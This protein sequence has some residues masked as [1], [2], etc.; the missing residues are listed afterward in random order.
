MDDA[1]IAGSVFEEFVE[2]TRHAVN[3]AT[4]P[5][6]ARKITLN[7]GVKAIDAVSTVI[8]TP[9]QIKDIDGVSLFR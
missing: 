2:R 7:P 6:R 5:E 3:H 8:A 9:F 1:K 4:E